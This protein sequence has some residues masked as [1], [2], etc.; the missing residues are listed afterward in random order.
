MER[1]GCLVIGVILALI[2]LV[3]T[4]YYWSGWLNRPVGHSPAPALTF[5]LEGM[6]LEAGYTAMDR[7]DG[8]LDCIGVSD[9]PNSP[10]KCNAGLWYRQGNALYS[11]P[12]RND[13]TRVR[14]AQSHSPIRPGQSPIPG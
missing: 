11:G 2:I 8:I 10:V 4:V 12:S 3:V 7:M 1:Y 5:T 6:E 14:R 9:S 13:G